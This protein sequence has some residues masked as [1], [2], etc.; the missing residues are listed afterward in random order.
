M[1]TRLPYFE[2]WLTIRD[3]SVNKTAPRTPAVKGDANTTDG[4]YFYNPADAPKGLY[5][6]GNLPGSAAQG[7]HSEPRKSLRTLD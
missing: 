4:G 5:L 6:T 7:V 1:S 3:Y 2:P